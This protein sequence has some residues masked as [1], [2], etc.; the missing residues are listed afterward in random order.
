MAFMTRPPDSPLRPAGKRPDS[1]FAQWRETFSLAAHYPRPESVGGATSGRW[2]LAGLVSSLVLLSLL[3]VWSLPTW[4]A[5]TSS[6]G[7]FGRLGWAFISMV[8]AWYG[9]FTATGAWCLRRYPAEWVRRGWLSIFLGTT[10]FS[11]FWFGLLAVGPG[12]T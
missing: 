1:V 4:W 10:V 11:L 12:L 8:W 2:V 7:R 3:G 9:L 6:S 5:A